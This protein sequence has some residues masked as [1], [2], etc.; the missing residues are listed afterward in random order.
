MSSEA[1]VLTCSNEACE[2]AT[3]GKCVEGNLLE[4]CPHLED[5]HV[6]EQGV[7]EDD[8][9][10]TWEKFQEESF[11]IGIDNGKAL[12]VEKASAILKAR[13][14]PVIALVGQAEAGKTSLIAEVYDAFQYGQYST[15][16]FGGSK[17]LVAFEKICHKA[18]GASRGLDLLE[19][20]TDRTADPVFYHLSMSTEEGTFTDVFIADRSGETYRDVLDRPTL[21][22]H[23]LELRR[24]TVLNLLVDGGRLCDSVERA[25]VVSECQ[26]V[27]QSL[28][29]SSLITPSVRL[30]VV[31]TKV[32]VVDASP[33]KERVDKDFQGIVE[34]IRRLDPIAC[35]DPGVYKIAARPHG[36]VY[37]KGHGVEGLVRDWIDRVVFQTSYKP[38]V[39]KSKRA[40]E[41]VRSSLEAS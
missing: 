24:A 9:S 19:E 40:I 26:Q 41:L 21:S 31:L 35:L 6:Q 4:D 29:F 22:N 16:S 28:A 5:V 13:G 17:T 25:S 18:R 8:A 15:L 7:V 11:L 14:A 33:A 39:Y 34:R 1:A 3:T 38:G 10:G 37:K 20:R 30:N 36:E 12:S 23:C 32:D 27:M 2:Y